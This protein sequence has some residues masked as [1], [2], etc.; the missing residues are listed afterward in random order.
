[1]NAQTTDAPAR[2]F[3]L[4]DLF[5]REEVAALTARSDARGLWAVVSTWAIIAGSFALVAKWT[6]ALTIV[7][8]LCLIAGR[9]LALAILQHEGAHGTLFK[10]RWMNNVFTDWVCARPVWQHLPKYRAH[11]LIHHTKTGSLQDPDISLHVGYPI[12]RGSMVR[13]L[14]RDI[15]GVTGLKVVL[16]MVAMDLEI[17]KWT[18][19]NKLERLPR[20]PLW[21]YPLNLIKN[22]AGMVI[23]NL[24][25]YGILRATGHGWLYGLWVLAYITP[26]PAFV[27][28]RSIAEHGVLPRTPEIHLNTRTT[29]ANTL[30]RMVIAPV[31]VNFHMEHHVMASVP[32]YRLPEMHQMLRDRNAVP[33][34]PGYWHVMK[35]ATNPAARTDVP[36]AGVAA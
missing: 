7:I 23:T 1:M 18:V 27:R 31:H 3:K 6:N 33:T 14:L 5:S 25:L 34:P 36:D 29:K 24:V 30:L 17:L 26:F 32:Y 4:N 16:G 19:A 20:Q 8:A 22:S 2:P 28:I 10:T 13:K 11:H 35:L 12:T 15:V 21:K 9:Q